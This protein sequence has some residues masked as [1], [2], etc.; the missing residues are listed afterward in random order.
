MNFFY[1]FKT[2]LWFYLSYSVFGS[3]WDLEIHEI[4]NV[5][6]THSFRTAQMF[7]LF[8][9]NMKLWFRC[10]VIEWNDLLKLLLN[11]FFCFIKKFLFKKRKLYYLIYCHGTWF[12]FSIKIYKKTNKRSFSLNFIGFSLN[13][14]TT[15]KEYRWIL[16]NEI[17][18]IIY[19]IFN[20]N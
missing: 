10:A 6:R 2:Q 14:T 13:L 12:F 11:F 19:F 8:Y 5:I 16:K 15:K 1:Q 4:Q 20:S 18:I 3:L 17:L 7:K 9:M